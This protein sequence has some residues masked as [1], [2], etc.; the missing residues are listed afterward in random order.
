MAGIEIVP[1]A[2][3]H[4]AVACPAMSP[5]H[6]D[7][8]ELRIRK[9]CAGPLENNVYVVACGRTGRSV[10]IDAA[11]EPERIVVAAAGTTP[12]AV[13]TTHGHHDHVGAAA[14]VCRALGVPFRIHA[15]DA[16]LAGL[17]PDLAIEDEDEIAVGEL[18]VRALH[19]PGH[20]PG[21]TC[22]LVGTQLFS[23]DTLFPGGPG[24]TGDAAAFS[25]VIDSLRTRLFTLPDDT[26]VL[27]GHGLDTT[28]GT[29][30]PALGGWVAR[31]Y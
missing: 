26:V 14:E 5:W 31:G 7:D 9:M 11:A 19:T 24:A 18:S 30:R 29:E 3:E 4:F 12:I 23:G 1:A 10:V 28:I 15:A 20:T 17:P 21:S 13:L 22:F 27:P 6:H 8:G 25:R 16:A 2:G